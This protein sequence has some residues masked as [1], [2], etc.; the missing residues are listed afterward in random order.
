MKLNATRR[1]GKLDVCF[2]FSS[3]L[4]KISNVKQHF[5]LQGNVQNFDVDLNCTFESFSDPGKDPHQ[6]MD[7]GKQMFKITGGS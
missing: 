1:R 7:P 3:L 5:T 4:L 2:I 6:E